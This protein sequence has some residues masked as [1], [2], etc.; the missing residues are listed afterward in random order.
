MFPDAAGI[1]RVVAKRRGEGLGMAVL[2]AGIAAA[3]GR[4]G[5]GR[6]R[7]EAQSHAVGFYERAGFAVCGEEFDEDGI[8]HVPMVLDTAEA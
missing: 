4:F 8:P 6:I 1:G 3:R 2:R 7:L 5:A